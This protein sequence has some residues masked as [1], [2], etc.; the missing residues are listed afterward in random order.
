PQDRLRCL[1]L[2]G[3]NGKGSVGAMIKSV[4]DQAGYRIGF[5]T[6]PHLISFRERFVIGPDMISERDVAR[7]TEMVKGVCS[8]DEPPTFFE[9]VTAMA[10]EYLTENQVDLAIME[11]GLG[12]RLDATNVIKPLAAVITNIS[13]DHTQH[14]G[15]TLAQIAREKAG[16]IKPNLPV[17]T[18]E[19]RKALREIFRQKA[20]SLGGR[21][22]VLG[23]DFTV[24]SR[25]R[26]VF[27]YRGLKMNFEGLELSLA[28]SHQ[29]Q[30]AGLAL[31]ALEVTA[32]HGY[33]ASE[34]DIRLGLKSTVWPGRG[35]VFP[36]PPRIMLDGAHNPAAARVLGQFLRELKY[37]RLHLVLG[38]MAD[39]DIPRLMA[40][41]LG[42]AQALYLCRPQYFRAASTRVLAGLA[43]GFTGPVAEY[44]TVGEAVE[45]A[46]AEAGPEDLILVTGSLFT[47]G[48][49]RAY[50]TGLRSDPPA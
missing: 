39:K 3:T 17:V 10:I 26:G 36:G 9:I 4:L 27:D 41:L 6:S 8:S 23:R 12:G 14:L 32:D 46:K 42:S 40:P 5:Y 21:L 38:V 19:K 20:E 29:V 24:R 44:P 7:L 18:G 35:E 25:E 31:A 1:H 50:L 11:T 2:A 43:R 49:A 15:R 16:I 28:G 33:R 22:L 47:V 37:N 45:A 48:E 34:R 13:L 30:N